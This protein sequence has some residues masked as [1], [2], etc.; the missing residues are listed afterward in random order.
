MSPG[1]RHPKRPLKLLD[2]PLPSTSTHL[3]YEVTHLGYEVEVL[4]TFRV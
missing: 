4:G 2:L 1:E 3:G